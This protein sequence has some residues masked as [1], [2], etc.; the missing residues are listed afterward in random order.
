MKALAILLAL[1]ATL[2]VAQEKVNLDLYY[3]SL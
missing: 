1:T 2:V 3:E